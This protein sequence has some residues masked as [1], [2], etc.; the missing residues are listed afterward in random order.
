V[1]STDVLHG[2]MGLVDKAMMCV[3][4][5]EHRFNLVFI[6]Y[7]GCVGFSMDWWCRNLAPL[8]LR[9]KHLII[10]VAVMKILS[11]SS[12]F[13][14][15]TVDLMLV[16]AHLISIQNIFGFW[17]SSSRA[18]V[19]PNG[20]YLQSNTCAWKLQLVFKQESNP[21]DGLI[22]S[23]IRSFIHSVVFYI[24]LLR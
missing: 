7:G 17:S 8:S 16:L 23:F 3:A 5:F 1:G 11:W 15:S 13:S 21:S 22:H 10:F 19:K 12:S 20:E 6:A 14:S 2:L 4:Q 9:L 18:R 24:T